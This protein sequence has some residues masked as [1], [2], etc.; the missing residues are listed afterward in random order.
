MADWWSGY[1]RPTGVVVWVEFTFCVRYLNKM[2][3]C[4]YKFTWFNLKIASTPDSFKEV[5]FLYNDLSHYSDCALWTIAN[6]LG[7]LTFYKKTKPNWWSK[8]YKHMCLSWFSFRDCQYSDQL[9]IV[10]H[11]RNALFHEIRTRIYFHSY[12]EIRQTISSDFTI[13]RWIVWTLSHWRYLPT[14]K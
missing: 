11:N 1:W 9:Y 13:S 12:G 10:L 4:S 2:S 8:W 7:G 3:A 14:V 6:F 5:L